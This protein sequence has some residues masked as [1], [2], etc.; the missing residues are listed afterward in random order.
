MIKILKC[1]KKNY[2]FEL[3]KFFFK[4]QGRLKINTNVVKK[5]INDEDR[6]LFF[7]DL[8]NEPW[9]GYPAK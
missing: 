7:S 2:Q 8:H 4:R 9:Y 3:N 6:K 5:I 1:E